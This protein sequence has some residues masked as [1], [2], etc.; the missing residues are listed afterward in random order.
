MVGRLIVGNAIGALIMLDDE[1]GE[2]KDAFQKLMVFHDFAKQSTIYLK[3]DS[4]GVGSLGLNDDRMTYLD[5]NVEK[6]SEDIVL[7]INNIEKN[8]THCFEGIRNYLTPSLLEDLAEVMWYYAKK[9]PFNVQKF[10]ELQELFT[11]F[12]LFGPVEETKDAPVEAVLAQIYAKKQMGGETTAKQ[13]VKYVEEWLLQQIERGHSEACFVLVSGLA[14][15]DL[16]DIEKNML[17]K[18]VEQSV[19]L[20]QSLQ[21]RLYLLE[22]GDMY[23]LKVYDNID[24]EKY[25]FD[26]STVEWKNNE[27]DMF[28]HMLEMKKIKLQYSLAVNKWTNNTPLRA[29]QKLDIDELYQDFYKMIDDFDGEVTMYVQNAKAINMSNVEYDDAAIFKFNSKRNRCITVLFACEKYGR[30]LASTIITL[31]EP[32]DKYNYDEQKNFA[33]AIKNNIYVESFKEQI[34]QAIDNV[35][36]EKVEIYSDNSSNIYG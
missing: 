5:R 9:T 26:D 25:M 8:D 16:Y 18:M 14:W 28:F 6:I 10:K 30:N 35:L 34:Y 29:G 4:Y 15:L 27:Y 21:E 23:K 20:P 31:F 22:S 36:K 12:M 3:M 19:Q 2:L 7:R 24:K 11:K 13:E 17:N 32:D 1:N 33:I